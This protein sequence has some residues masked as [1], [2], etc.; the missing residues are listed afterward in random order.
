MERYFD[1]IIAFCDNIARPVLIAGLIL[2]G[3]FYVHK[4]HNGPA[5]IAAAGAIFMLVIYP[6]LHRKRR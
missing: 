2:V 1:A 3:L 5:L 6:I 4:G